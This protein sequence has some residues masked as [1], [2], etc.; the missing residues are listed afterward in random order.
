MEL[1]PDLP[2]EDE[3]EERWPAPE[4]P[5]AGRTRECTSYFQAPAPPRP[6]RRR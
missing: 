6:R 1:M 3:D 5:C 4:E 2:D